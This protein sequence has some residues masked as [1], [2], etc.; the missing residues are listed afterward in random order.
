MLSKIETLNLSNDP[1]I[2]FDDCE[3][4]M[5]FLMGTAESVSGDN[6]N[7]MTRFGRGLVYICITQDQ[8]RVLNLSL[9]GESDLSHKKTFTISVDHKT[10]TTGISADERANTIKAFIQPHVKPED[11]RRPGHIFPLIS[12]ER[13]LLDR[14]GIA[15]AAVLLSELKSKYPAAYACEI[16]NEDG[17]VANRNE[18]DQL[19]RRLGLQILNLSEL[20][21]Y[22]FESTQWLQIVDS[23]HI[24]RTNNIWVFTVNNELDKQEFKLFVRGGKNISNNVMFYQECQSG[25][26]LGSDQCEC[27]K[28][29]KD[30]YKQLIN[31]NI[32]AIVFESEHHST[33]NTT[34]KELIS[35]QIKKILKEISQSNRLNKIANF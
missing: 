1:I 25:D 28:H 2:L 29:F 27:N 32:D 14:V 24:D 26:L 34:T 4:E 31:K 16:L 10:T 6:V 7:F 21:N 30:Y 19:S 33:A 20:V 15:E 9:M 13:K 18:V 22:Q 5:A 3:S 12:K 23:R 11:F 35:K 8:A 17:E